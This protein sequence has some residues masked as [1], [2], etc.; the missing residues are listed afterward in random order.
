MRSGFLPASLPIITIDTKFDGPIAT[1]DLL[2]KEQV[3]FAEIAKAYD[4]TRFD[5]CT[6]K[7][8][9]GSKT[10]RG[11]GNAALCNDFGKQYKVDD[12]ERLE[13]LIET[14]DLKDFF[15]KAE[16]AEER[17]ENLQKKEKT[18]DPMIETTFDFHQPTRTI[19]RPYGFEAVAGMDELKGQLRDEVLL[20][21][22]DPEAQ[23]RYGMHPLNGMLLYGPPGCGKTFIAERFA[24]EAGM[25]SCF[26][27]CSDLG[28]TYAHGTQQIMAQLFTQAEEHKP[29]VVCIDEIDALLSNRSQ[30]SWS[31][32]AMEV[33]EFLT[34]M[35]NCNERGIFVIGTTNSPH[36]LDPAVLRTGRFDEKIY[37]P[38][39]DKEARKGIFQLKLSQ[40]WTDATIDYDRLAAL[41][42]NYVASDIGMIVNRAKL[43]AYKQHIP[44]SQSIIEQAVSVVKPSLSTKQLQQYQVGFAPENQRPQIGFATN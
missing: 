9:S 39:P 3:L 17:Q 27:K 44:V 35:N 42:A 6:P 37:V 23:Q 1:I 22:N 15:E 7:N 36:L 30:M 8:A 31:G 26:V 25:S 20:P 2:V 33:N 34:Q 29:S 28:S 16:K 38:L 14:P 12:D 32:Y 4:Y 40:T 24:E 19:N 5:S 21:L 13:S 43:L 10:I 11:L 18:Y 41:T